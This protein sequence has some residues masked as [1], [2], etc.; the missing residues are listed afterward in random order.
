MAVAALGIVIA[1]AG[2]SALAFDEDRHDAALDAGDHRL[3]EHAELLALTVTIA[4][5]V[6]AAREATRPKSPP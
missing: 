3:A 4:A 1:G 5:A 2:W 6:M